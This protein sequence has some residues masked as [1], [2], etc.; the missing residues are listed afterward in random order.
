M[1]DPIDDKIEELM[2]EGVLEVAGID[3]DTGEPLYNFTHKLKE[4][5]KDLYD[6]HNNYF[7]QDLTKLWEKGFID[8]DFFEEDPTVTI[9]EKVWNDNEINKLSPEEKRSLNEVKRITGDQA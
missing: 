5:N 7:F 3:I 6:I 8:I 9:T 4:Y 2:L 1:N